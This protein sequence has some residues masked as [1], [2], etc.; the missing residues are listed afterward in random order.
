M[1]L[2]LLVI[3]TLSSISREQQ[4]MTLT[5]DKCHQCAMV[6]CSCVY[7][8]WRSNGWQH[9]MKPDIGRESRVLRTASVFN[10]PVREG[11]PVK[12]LYG[13]NWNGVAT[14][15]FVLTEYT[16]VTDRRTDIAWRHRPRLCMASRAKMTAAASRT[17]DQVL[18]HAANSTSKI[19]TVKD[20]C[21]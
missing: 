20:Q 11:V 7:N 10:V 8:T 2:S 3:N 21:L 17:H 16:N 15:L 14:R 19:V 1:M 13:K 4:M 9:A 5:S 12:I 18:I 6:Q